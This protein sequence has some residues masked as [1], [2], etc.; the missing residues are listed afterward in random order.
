MV[1]QRRDI[2]L[3][4]SF[5]GNGQFQ[6]ER[7]SV[8]AMP[9]CVLRYIGAKVQQDCAPLLLSR[10]FLPCFAYVRAREPF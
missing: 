4:V 3:K 9:D 10:G 2:D 8:A 6:I 1:G 5:A 7:F